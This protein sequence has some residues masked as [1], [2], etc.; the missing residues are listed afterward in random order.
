MM[1]WMMNSDGIIS[2][3]MDTIL[4]EEEDEGNADFNWNEVDEAKQL[5]P[6]VT[7]KLRFFLIEKVV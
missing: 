5:T 6:A 1:K 7:N 4:L 3:W 2:E